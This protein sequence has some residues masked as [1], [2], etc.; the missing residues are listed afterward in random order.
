MK[1]VIQTG[2][3]VFFQGANARG[4]AVHGFGG[5]VFIEVAGK[6]NFIANL[7]FF[8]VHPGVGCVGLDFRFQ[9]GIDVRSEAD[10]FRVAQIFVGYGFVLFLDDIARLVAL[11]PFNGN[12]LVAEFLRGDDFALAMD[13]FGISVKGIVFKFRIGLDDELA[14][15]VG[16]VVAFVADGFA[17]RFIAGGSV[18]ELH[19]A[20]PVGGFVF[21]DEPDIGDDAGVHKLVGG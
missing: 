6:G 7:G 19:L 8:L 12:L 17:P 10:I 21:V 14:A 2:S 16:D 18:D 1:E 15:A 20:R 13:A 5:F 9:V 11:R 4:D 3:D